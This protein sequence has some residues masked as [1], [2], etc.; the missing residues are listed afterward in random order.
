MAA[1]LLSSVTECGKDWVLREAG[2]A[3]PQ[4]AP[5]KEALW[6]CNLTLG[7]HRIY[8]SHAVSR[9]SARPAAPSHGTIPLP[10]R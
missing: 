6:E 8:I 7:T 9:S 4:Y 10:N 3:D 2:K 5:A 1:F